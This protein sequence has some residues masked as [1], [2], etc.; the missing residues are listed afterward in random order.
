MC[1]ASILYFINA[2]RHY[3]IGNET[4]DVYFKYD[5]M[6]YEDEILATGRN[7]HKHLKQNIQLVEQE[8][9][10]GNFTNSKEIIS[11]S[12]Y[13]LYMKEKN[14]QESFQITS[15][16]ASEA[17]EACQVRLAYLLTFDSNNKDYNRAFK[18]IKHLIAK[19]N[20]AAISLLGYYYF[21]GIEVTKSVKKALFCF[22][23]NIKRSS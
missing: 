12:Y 6:S 17:D 20:P 1:S 23:S 21:K 14:I 11:Y 5:F 15:L 19:K 7:S 8:M 16:C 18:I 3:F 2:Y 4:T 22:K 13:G 10:Y 9:L